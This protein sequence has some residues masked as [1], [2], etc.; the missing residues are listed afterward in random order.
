MTYILKR[1]MQKHA[2]HVRDINKAILLK[3]FR[4]ADFNLSQTGIMLE[5]GAERLIL[6]MVPTCVAQ[7]YEAHQMMFDLKGPSG[8]NPCPMCDNCIG[9]RAYFE[10][11]S[12]FEHVLSPRY[13]RFKLR[14]TS[15]I[16]EIA[17][18]LKSLAASGASSDL[19]SSEKATGFVYEPHGLLFD[20]DVSSV[21]ELPRAIYCDVCHSVSASGGH[22][23]IC[24]KPF[25]SC[26]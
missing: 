3:L 25:L 24:N 18:E 2:I 4:H 8:L 15:R 6:V 20:D 23:S 7:D 14:D 5:H 22:W 17:A 21:F 10:D 19:D 1:T 13:D 9:R 26:Q 16:H 12:Y 11:D